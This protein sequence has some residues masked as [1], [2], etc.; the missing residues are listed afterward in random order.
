MKVWKS[1]QRHLRQHGRFAATRIG[2]GMILVLLMSACTTLFGENKPPEA[3][4]TSPSPNATLNVGEQVQI[5]GLVTGEGITKVDIVI[6]NVTYASL[7]A[8][9]PSVGVP[10]FPIGGAESP[11]PWT[12]SSAGTH[13]LQLVVYGAPDNAL[14][15]KSE[16]I[17]VNALAANAPA[18]T[19][20]TPAQPQPA[21]TLP[22]APQAATPAPAPGNNANAGQGQAPAAGGAPSLTVVNDFVNVRKG[23]GVGYEKLGTLDK[24]QSAPVKGKSTDGEWLQISY[25][26]AANGVGWVKLRDAS[27][28]LVQP[29]DAARNVPVAAAPPLPAVVAAPAV[30]AA[31]VAAPVIVPIGQPATAVPPNVAVVAAPLTGAR[32]VLRVNANPVASGSIA[33]ATWNI[34]NFKDGEFDKGDGNGF[35]GPIAGAMT[36]D[37]PGVTSARTLRLRWRDIAGTQLED[38][39]LLQVAGQAAVVPTTVVTADC[40]PSNPDWKGNSDGTG[41]YNFCARKDLGY[42]GGG[43][44][45]VSKYSVGEDKT[46]TLDWNIYGIAGIRFVVEPSAQWCGPQGTKTIDRSTQGAGSESFN[47]KDLPYGGYIVHLK[48]KK[49]DGVEV[50]YN[51]K[52]ICVGTGNT[53]PTSTVAP[54]TA[55]ATAIPET[56]TGGGGGG[57]NAT[58]IPTAVDATAIP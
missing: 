12:P 15:A 50:N 43:V 6:D 26:S 21:A 54:T 41:Q 56:P 10:S 4:I 20:P 14:K 58:A 53:S 33:Y 30:P 17:V 3:K 18:V 29:N 24:G 25:P 13:A 38:T 5:E 48:V 47:I 32:N 19:E 9:D 8:P 27:D 45:N 52:F 35:R 42:V 55:P 34:P 46:L 40:N 22:P 2:A 28:T 44:D 31:P 49:R 36:V 1:R 57:G 23:P 51:E 39:L 7:S 11:V 16:P 37:V